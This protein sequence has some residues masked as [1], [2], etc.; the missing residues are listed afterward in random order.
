[1][2]SRELEILGVPDLGAEVERAGM[3]WLH[4]PIVDLEAPGDAFLQ[5]WESSGPCLHGI[6]SRGG[7]VLLHCRGGLGRTGTLAAQLLIEAGARSE[8]AIREVRRAR[9]GA[10]E[11]AAQER[12]L[13]VFA[14]A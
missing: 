2:E 6:L 10:I 9:P 8:D 5:L 1:M 13:R 14:A 4:L 3:R 11:T 12:Y 7:R